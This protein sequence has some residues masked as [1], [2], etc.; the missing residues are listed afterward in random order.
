MQDRQHSFAS[1]QVWLLLSEKVLQGAYM[2]APKH[3][4][5]DSLTICASPEPN[6]YAFLPN[7]YAL[8]TFAWCTGSDVCLLVQYKSCIDLD[9]QGLSDYAEITGSVIQH[10]SAISMKPSKGKSQALNT[11][12]M[13]QYLTVT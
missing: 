8:C 3:K 11:W 9:G 4:P 1:A 7:C 5:A 2:Q 12:V 10:L 6:R 13:A